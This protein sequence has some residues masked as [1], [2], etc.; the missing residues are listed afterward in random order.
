MTT[1]NL[2][3][4][5]ITNI[6]V[7]RR[8]ENAVAEV[9]FDYAAWASEFGAGAVTL[10]VKRIHDSNAY[11]VVVTTADN[12]ATWLVTST[13]TAYVGNGTAEFIY[14]INEQIAKSAVISFRV[15]Q[16]IGEPLPTPPD[17]Y[18]TWIDTLTELGAETL[19]NAQDAASSASDAAIAK[20]AS[21]TAQ[22]AAETAQGKAE[23]A[24]TAAEAALAEF[25]S[26]TASANTLLPNQSATAN[27]TNGH[28]T[29]GIPKGDTGATGADGQDGQDGQDGFSPTVAVTAITG[30]HEVT[31]TDAQGDHS[32]NV[33][34]GEQ[35]ASGDM[36]IESVSG[37]TPTI[38]GVANHRYVCGEVSTI[39]ITPPSSG[40]CDVIF[41]SGSTAAVLT[42]PNTVIFP[43]WFDATALEANVIYEI[44]IMDGIYGAVMSWQT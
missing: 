43:V 18:E 8:G 37:S 11:P 30:G 25:T 19:Q 23:D 4:N 5:K 13:D 41:E 40:I 2:A 15:L 32:F 24:Q 1:I 21:E 14:T 9:V 10:L 3:T 27:Y 17:P 26:P 29:F 35:G 28:F 38:T 33:M 42:V 6:I 20:T 12:K 16:D 34:D 7:G 36:V 22:T 44:N 31:I 39:S